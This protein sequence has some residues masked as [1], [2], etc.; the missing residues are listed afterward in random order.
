VRSPRRQRRRPPRSASTSCAWWT[1]P[2]RR[3]WTRFARSWSGACR[4][5]S[6]F[7]WVAEIEVAFLS[8]VLGGTRR[9]WARRTIDVKRLA[10]AVDRRTDPSSD[11]GY[12]LATV[13]RRYGLPVE[14]A[15][16]AFDDALMT[17]ELFLVLATRL[18]AQGDGTIARLRRLG[19]V[20]RP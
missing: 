6:C 11:H 17:A 12:A 1:W 20:R 19:R 8:R 18:A 9:A 3:R 2:A 16:H 10:E 13:A 7:A 15:H 14:R 5:A 4:A